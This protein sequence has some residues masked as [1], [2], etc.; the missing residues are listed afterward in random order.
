MRNFTLTTL[1]SLI[2]IYAVFSQETSVL[3]LGNSYTNTQ[4]LPAT[5]YNLALEGGDTLIYDS[6]TPGGYTLNGH[7][8]NA[9]SLSK[10]ASRDWDFVVLQEQSQM[11]SFGDAQ[12]AAEVFPYAEILVD[13]IRS[14]YECSEPVFFMTWGRRDGDQSNCAGFPALCTYEGMQERLRNAYLQMTF[15]NDVTVGPC[16]AAWQQMALNNTQFFTG[17]YA[18]DGSHPSAWGTYLNACVFYATILKKSPVGIEYYS[19]I[20]ETDAV[21]LQQL[22]EDVV[23]DSLSTWNIGHADVNSE[24]AYDYYSAFIVEFSSNSDNA[25]SHLWDFGDGQTSSLENPVHTYSTDNL[26]EV[27]HI[28]YS[29]CGTDTTILEVGSNPLAIETSAVNKLTIVSNN[30]THVITN[31]TSVN[32]QLEVL[33]VTGRITYHAALKGNSNLV[34][35][36]PNIAGIKLIRI[37]NDSETRTFKVY[38]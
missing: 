7:S 9:T 18:N 24:A 13:S 35:D 28:A 27:T 20:G 17:L 37:S 30:G 11:P 34:I 29:A 32:F 5:L 6:N 3:F 14:N 26:F 31:P 12:V 4:N 22:A 8:T 19:T 23:L 10:I 33:D 2:T 25:T 16:G 21:V 38:D 15:D 36:Q 1:V